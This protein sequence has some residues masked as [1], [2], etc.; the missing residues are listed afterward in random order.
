MILRSISYQCLLPASGEEYSLF[1][2]PS[3]SVS[4]GH[5]SDDGHSE[6]WEAI[7]S[8]GFDLHLSYLAKLTS[9]HVLSFQGW[10]Q[11]PSWFSFLLL[12]P[13]LNSFLTTTPRTFV[14][15]SCFWHRDP[16]GL[17]NTQ[18]PSA[19]LFKLLLQKMATRRQHYSASHIP[20]PPPRRAPIFVWLFSWNRGDFWFY[21]WTWFI[22]VW[23]FIYSL[24]SSCSHLGNYSVFS[25]IQ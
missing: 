7:P 1:S 2:T 10:V 18:C 22:N 3:P 4:A 6:C 23:A 15:I 17:E 14:E 25:K 11:V 9:S 24:S 13:V 16:F 19:Q 8:C 20:R 5:I 21:V 12:G